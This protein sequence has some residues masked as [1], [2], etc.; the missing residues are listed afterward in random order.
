MRTRAR[1][2]AGRRESSSAATS[3]SLR[4]AQPEHPGQRTIRT[5]VTRVKPSASG[6]AHRHVMSVPSRVV[7]GTPPATVAEPAV[8]GSADHRRSAARVLVTGSRDW[9]DEGTIRSELQAWWNENGR[10]C[11]AVLVHGACRT[12]ADAIADRIWS[13]QGLPIER[14]PAPWNALDGQGQRLGRRAGPIRNQQ[15]V[16]M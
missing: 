14:H 2:S 8:P 11:D 9:S 10:P 12:G 15:M 4:G 3:A 1:A 7:V 6:T 16:R 13:A 5:A